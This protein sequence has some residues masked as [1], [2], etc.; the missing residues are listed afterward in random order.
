MHDSRCLPGE[1]RQVKT[2]LLTRRRGWRAAYHARHPHAVLRTRAACRPGTPGPTENTPPMTTGKA[3]ER[4]V[5][6]AAYA[7]DEGWPPSSYGHCATA[8]TNAITS[9]ITG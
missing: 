4:G 3:V 9:L 8:S 6:T 5:F 7:A 2:W 1:G